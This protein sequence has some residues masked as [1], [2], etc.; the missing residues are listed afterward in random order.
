MSPHSHMISHL[1]CPGLPK[2]SIVN[3]DS[4]R[5]GLMHGHVAAV[6][7]VCRLQYDCTSL[8]V[9]ADLA[10]VGLERSRVGSRVSFGRLGSTLAPQF[11]RSVSELANPPYRHIPILGA[12]VGSSSISFN[13]SRSYAQLQRRHQNAVSKSMA[14]VLRTQELYQLIGQGESHVMLLRVKLG[15]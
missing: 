8:A 11:V 6:Q 5:R 15:S 13:S 4:V 2:I 9:G 1:V 14:A 3:L 12:V 10:A 7:H